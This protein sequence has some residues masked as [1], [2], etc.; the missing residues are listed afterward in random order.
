MGL[1]L[2][3]TIADVF[4]TGMFDTSLPKLT[5]KPKF[6]KK[7]ID[8]IITTAPEEKIPE[9]INILN[10]YDENQRLKFTHEIEEDHKINFLDMTLIHM[11]NHKIKTNWY[12]E[13]T[14]SKRIVNFLSSHPPKMKENVAIEFV[15]RVMALSDPIFKPINVEKIYKILSKNN[16][17]TRV[18][19]KAMAIHH[20]KQEQKRQQIQQTTQGG[21]T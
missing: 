5:F 2:A 4:L 11:R 17:P 15:N 10:S 20:H 9:T 13:A 14:S 12:S 16:Y 7:F 19:K 21:D 18:I 1:S 8:D 6:V 3:C